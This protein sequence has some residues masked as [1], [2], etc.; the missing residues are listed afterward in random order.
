[1]N[2]P[3]SRRGRP[4]TASDRTGGPLDELLDQLRSRIPG[5]IVER[6]QVT[7]RADD[8]NVYF[9]G[10]E[11][12]L[13]RIQLDTFP[14]GQPSFCI[15]NGGRHQTSEVAEAASIIGSYLEQGRP[16]GTTT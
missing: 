12:G 5:L 6:L 3:S 15:E 4:W 2:R 14:D 7:H 13:D 10:D 1:M 9:I 8:D 16:P 11:Y